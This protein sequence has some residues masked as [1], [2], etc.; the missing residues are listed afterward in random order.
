MTTTDLK[1]IMR[2]HNAILKVCRDPDLSA[3]AK[4]FVILAISLWADERQPAGVR[5]IGKTRATLRAIAERSGDRKGL[6]W[7]QKVIRE[8]IPRYVPPV[9]EKRV[10]TAP[11]I[12]REGECGKSPIS[13]GILY[14][15]ITGE[16][17]WYGFC[18]RHRNHHDDW[19]IQQ[20]NKQ[21]NINGRPS[22][23]PNQG[24]LLRRYLDTDWDE[25]YQ[26]AAPYQEPLKGER[27]PTFPRPELRIIAGGA[28]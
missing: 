2:E 16:G 6:W 23:G 20:Q 7:I 1:A 19:A 12:R 24:G 25:Y 11:M 10:C 3:D 18:S 9:P 5:K 8:D 14:D 26:W 22:P 17:T 13:S 4:L 15:P 21:W 27:A 28:S